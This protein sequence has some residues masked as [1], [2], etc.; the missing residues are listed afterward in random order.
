MLNNHLLFCVV[1]DWRVTY[2]ASKYLFFPLQ[3]LK[4]CAWER[5][6]RNLGSIKE[7][8][9]FPFLSLCI[10]M[11]YVLLTFQGRGWRYLL[12]LDKIYLFTGTHISI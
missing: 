12:G 5:G 3:Q 8:L 7:D 6:T 2:S 9:S 1:W 11:G 10:Y 4:M